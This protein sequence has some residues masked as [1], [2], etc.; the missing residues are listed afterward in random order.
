V[1]KV[2]EK[3]GF[4]RCLG[5]VPI[6]SDEFEIRY[7][8]GSLCVAVFRNVVPPEI[9]EHMTSKAEKLTG[10]LKQCG[11]RLAFSTHFGGHEYNPRKKQQDYYDGKKRIWKLDDGTTKDNVQ[12][13][14][15]ELL[16]ANDIL[17]KVAP[18]IYERCISVPGVFR[19]A[20][21]AFTRSA[22]N[23]T[24]CR[25]HRD[26]DLGLDVIFYGGDWV[27]GNLRFPQLDLD[28]YLKPGDIVV[29]DGALFHLVTPI[30]GDRISLVFFT[31]RHNKESKSKEILEVPEEL[32]WLNMKNFGIF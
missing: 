13:F 25:M 15:P 23:I 10:S 8:D 30:A 9:T 2:V 32:A 3:I 28:I 1:K 14:L 18:D 27:G 12:E 7:K 5:E 4:R 17:K 20:Q 26:N 6:R 16:L 11:T 29:M 21:T 22:L 24:E 31:K 19:M